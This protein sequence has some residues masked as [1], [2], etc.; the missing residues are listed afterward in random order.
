[1]NSPKPQAK[2]TFGLTAKNMEVIETHINKW[3]GAVFDRRTWENIGEEIGWDAFT[4]ALWYFRKIRGENA[5]TKN[6]AL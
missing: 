3:D 2:M 1:M 6:P 4:A 5:E